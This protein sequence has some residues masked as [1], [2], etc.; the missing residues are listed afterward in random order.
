MALHIG[1]IIK[2]LVKSKGL[3]VTNFADKV[4]YSRRNVYE[5]FNKSTIDTG[6][7]IKVSKVLDK[8]LFLNYL[9][10]SDLNRLKN[11]K[12]TAE[13]LKEILT[14]M[15]AEVKRLKEIKKQ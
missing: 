4:G 7:L 11:D 10:D 12:T 2:D 1:K 8:N 6:L 3:T 5:I 14:N 9:S 13:E 15:K